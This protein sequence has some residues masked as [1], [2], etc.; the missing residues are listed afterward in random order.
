GSKWLSTLMIGAQFAVASFLLIVVTVTAL[1][2]AHLK[3]TGLASASDPLVLI[4]NPS[5]ITKVDP[6]TLR[7]ELGRVPQVHGVSEIGAPP[8]VN[9]S[10]TLV[11]ATPEDNAASKLVTNQTVG[12]DFFSVFDIGLVAGR[13]FSRDYRDD[14]DFDSDGGAAPGSES[15]P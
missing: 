8:W 10:G 1:E 9:L 3:R 6:A 13:V 7:A 4:E 2:N 14:A 5:S 12:F 15:K 11:T